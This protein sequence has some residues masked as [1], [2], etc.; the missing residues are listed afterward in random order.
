MDEVTGMFLKV[1]TLRKWDRFLKFQDIDSSDFVTTGIARAQSSVTFQA[2][3]GRHSLDSNFQ[4]DGVV[5]F[6][7]HR[8]HSPC[9]PDPNGEQLAQL[10]QGLPDNALIWY[11]YSCLPQEPRTPA[12][13]QKFQH[14]IQSLPELIKTAW[15]VILGTNIDD[16]GTRAWCQFEAVVALHCS[17]RP[18][19]S[20]FGTPQTPKDQ[21]LA[22]QTEVFL[23]Q[24]PLYRALQ[25][26]WQALPKDTESVLKEQE[27]D[28]YLRGYYIDFPDLNDLAFSGFK[29]AFFQLDAS[30][31]ADPPILWEIL[32]GLFPAQRG[33][34]TYRTD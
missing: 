12:Q 11:D 3:L 5:H 34:Y 33:D 16:Y 17:S 7:S 27:E 31:L 25:D 18:S 26:C 32:R 9:H 23:K 15:F 8:W 19:T 2:G 14:A 6:I 4:A 13:D 10:T 28:I 29:S 24:S 20:Y 30:A 21:R 1:S 22:R